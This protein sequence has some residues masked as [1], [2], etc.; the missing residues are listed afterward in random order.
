M[1][2]KIKIQSILKNRIK[3]SGSGKIF[4]KK[5]FRI[6]NSNFINKY[7]S[8]IKAKRFF[9]NDFTQLT[10]HKKICRLAQGL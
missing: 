7:K 9:K 2:K 3:V 10:G 5:R 6:N 4:Y 8:R 1:N